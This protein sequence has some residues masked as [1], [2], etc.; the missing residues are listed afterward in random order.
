M[1]QEQRLEFEKNFKAEQQ[2]GKDR[3]IREQRAY[4]DFLFTQMN[5]RKGKKHALKKYDQFSLNTSC[6]WGSTSNI[7][8]NCAI[9]RN[10]SYQSKI[11]NK[12]IYYHY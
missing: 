3:R 5:E 6:F 4:R 9:S 1:E 7:T 8:S 11:M 10:F 12:L 2:L